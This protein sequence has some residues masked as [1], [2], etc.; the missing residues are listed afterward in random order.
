MPSRWLASHES[1]GVVPLVSG[2]SAPDGILQDEWWGTEKVRGAAVCHAGC[3][4]R[5]SDALLSPYVSYTKQSR[6]DA[7]LLAA[8]EQGD[9]QQMVS[10]QVCLCYHSA[11]RSTPDH[12]PAPADYGPR[13]GSHNL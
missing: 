13:N 6:L 3:L 8:G 12:A 2:T 5:W 9:H 11:D 1:R 7:P 10:Q 4:P